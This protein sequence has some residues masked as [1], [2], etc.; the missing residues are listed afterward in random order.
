MDKLVAWNPLDFCL[1]STTPEF[2]IDENI[3]FLD[4]SYTVSLY[5][6]TRDLTAVRQDVSNLDN[7]VVV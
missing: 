7:S 6:M 4:L 2:F 3:V 1:L 5:L